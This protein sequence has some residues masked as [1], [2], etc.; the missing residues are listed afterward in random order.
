MGC[1]SNIACLFIFVDVMASS[2][3]FR[4]PFVL[5]PQALRAFVLCCELNLNASTM[6][7]TLSDLLLLF[8]KGKKLKGSLKR[9]LYNLPPIK[10]F[11]LLVMFLPQVCHHTSRFISP[12]DNTRLYPFLLS[13][14]L[15][16]T[17]RNAVDRN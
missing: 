7:Q 5:L 10:S 14:H 3:N 17:L 15:F 4:H 2:Q 12:R 16:Q 6:F 9:K 8:T 1:V 13:Q 11:Q